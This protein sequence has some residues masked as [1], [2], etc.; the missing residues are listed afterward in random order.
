MID[1]ILDEISPIN[2]RTR[3][4]GLTRLISDPRN[5]VPAKPPNHSHSYRLLRFARVPY[6][7][8]LAAAERSADFAR[9]LCP[10]PI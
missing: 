10:R 4:N 9:S 5:S 3:A 8:A 7:G 6:S 1:E 2:I